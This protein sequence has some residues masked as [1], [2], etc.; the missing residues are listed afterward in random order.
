MSDTDTGEYFAFVNGPPA[1]EPVVVTPCDSG[2]AF[3]DVPT[4]PLKANSR[5]DVE[6][7][8]NGLTIK[9][10]DSSTGQALRNARVTNHLLTLQNTVPPRDL[11]MT[12]DSGSVV[13][14]SLSPNAA[15]DICASLPDY[16][17]GCISNIQV[18]TEQQSQTIAL[19]R[20]TARTVRIES[21][22]EL[23]YGRTYVVLN[24]MIIGSSNIEQHNVIRIE[25]TTPPTAYLFLAA[26]NYP[27][28][29]LNLPNLAEA[30][31]TVVVPPAGGGLVTITLATESKH[32]GGPFT[33]G[34][35]GAPIPREILQYYQLI[36]NGHVLQ[37]RSGETVTVGPID[38]SQ[39]LS[40]FL[41]YWAKDAP[42][43]TRDAD[44][45]ESPAILQ[46]MYI[47]P[48]AGAETVL[49]P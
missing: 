24:S 44:P 28:T 45:F 18:T 43:D 30:E 5:Y 8:A 1:H 47:Q 27:L 22:G 40:I 10:V 49:S 29:R 11:G 39:P 46:R 33:L 48:L 35:A 37:I 21:P 9:V 31:P 16:E 4:R 20:S 38:T 17:T 23:D 13:D 36:Q 32:H 12:D 34:I 41:W 26:H 14:E 25:G 19:K 42:F 3:V 2:K 6:I 7:P 15:F